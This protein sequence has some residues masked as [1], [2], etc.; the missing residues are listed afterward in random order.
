MQTINIFPKIFV[1]SQFH[2]TKRIRHLCQNLGNCTVNYVLGF[3]NQ[4]TNVHVSFANVLWVAFSI[5]SGSLS[6]VIFNRSVE[7][8]IV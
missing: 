8:K 3:L 1:F 5:P 6:L 7:K 2:L 4:K